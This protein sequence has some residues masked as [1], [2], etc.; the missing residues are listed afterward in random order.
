MTTPIPSDPWLAGQPYEHFMGRWSRLIARAFVHWLSPAPEQ[1]WLDIGCGTGALS[2]A[3]LTLAM[4]ASVIA[5]D[6]SAAFIEFAQHRLAD[7]RMTFEVG[8]VLDL[9]ATAYPPDIAVS[10][11]VLNFLPN[12]VTALQGI[13]HAVKP[14]GT[15]ALYVW[16]YGGKMEMLRY[17]WDSV[18]A[19]N[20]G[21]RALDEGTRFPICHPEA[22]ARA[23]NEAGLHHTEVNALE[24]T[25]TFA[26]FADYWSP[27]LGGQGPAPAYVATLG[28][29]DRTALEEHLRATLPLN[30]DGSISLV[31]RAWAVRAAP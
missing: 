22:L 19:L 23:C 12:P 18:V 31:A 26:D 30:E 14:E 16:D 13:R 8:S 10:G 11:L 25:M 7:P 29:A 2:E 20:P 21:A 15:I 27:L 5:I 1:R 3:I 9:P 28:V 6:P 4:P 24:A 17:F